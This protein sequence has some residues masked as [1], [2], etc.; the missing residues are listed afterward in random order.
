M[1]QGESAETA[2]SVEV[3][4][5]LR[6]VLSVGTP[7]AVYNSAGDVNYNEVAALSGGTV[8]LACP[9]SV[10]GSGLTLA[11]YVP[12]TVASGAVIGQDAGMVYRRLGDAS[13]EP[14]GPSGAL[15]FGLIYEG[16]GFL[17]AAV[18]SVR[19]AH[20]LGGRSI[21]AIGFS[22]AASVAET[23]RGYG[24][25]A[26]VTPILRTTVDCNWANFDGDLRVVVT[27]PPN[28]RGEQAVSPTVTLS[29]SSGSRTVSG[30]HHLG[31]LAN[32]VGQVL[33]DLSPGEYSASAAE[34]SY[35]DGR[36]VVPQLLGNPATVGAQRRPTITVNYAYVPGTVSFEAV[37]A[38]AAAVATLYNTETGV[39]TSIPGNN[40]PLNVDPGVYIF[41]APP[42]PGFGDPTPNP[43]TITV[44]S[45]VGTPV[46]VVYPPLTGSLYVET[47]DAGAL[48]PLRLQSIGEGSVDIRFWG[49][50]PLNDLPAGQY[51]LSASPLAEFA[52]PEPEEQIITIAS[53]ALNRA[54]VEYN[55]ISLLDGTVRLA[56]NA[57]FDHDDPNISRRL[58]SGIP[59]QLVIRDT[60]VDRAN[61]RN[62]IRIIQH[63]YSI[64]SGSVL[65]IDLDEQI[66]GNELQSRE[67][68]FE[69]FR[70]YSFAESQEQASLL[71]NYPFYNNGGHIIAGPLLTDEH[72]PKISTEQ[73]GTPIERLRIDLS[74]NRLNKIDL[75]YYA[76]RIGSSGAASGSRRV[77]PVEVTWSTRGVQSNML[78]IEVRREH[79][80]QT[81]PFEAEMV[82][83][84]PRGS[85][86]NYIYSSD[87]V[88]G[89][90]STVINTLEFSGFT[91]RPTTGVDGVSAQYL[92]INFTPWTNSNV[93]RISGQIVIPDIFNAQVEGRPV[94]SLTMSTISEIGRI[95]GSAYVSGRI[96]SITDEDA[97][98]TAYSEITNLSDPLFLNIPMT[99]HGYNTSSPNFTEFSMK[100]L[101]VN[102]FP[103][104]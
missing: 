55:D 14:L 56:F 35:G 48:A 90:Y 8:T 5:A 53:N 4:P 50:Q 75:L 92:P 80:G 96:H 89:H 58:V 62:P 22:T 49:E 34:L 70:P 78:N 33:R 77:C 46:R 10:V 82:F 6:S 94:S 17:P 9:V 7:V 44:R 81:I 69:P 71:F 42:V 91:F 43:Q 3:P 104:R 79:V 12:V 25:T 64:R 15:Q 18:A 30:W 52:P 86:I 87:G 54:R 63:S 85:E 51:R 32:Q 98:R 84:C 76:M 13:F 57:S 40:Q 73:T 72:P 19:P 39:T 20:E 65:L 103:I 23:E 67:A 88:N 28:V 100:P 38:G 66:Q 101:V 29:G 37:N 59:G 97:R 11:T 16:Q 61:S 26:Q 24:G 31:G 102:F 83:G 95:Q 60:V 36:T 68:F 99:T 93:I 41:T 45:R 2:T 21:T 1:P 27:A 47:P 74:P